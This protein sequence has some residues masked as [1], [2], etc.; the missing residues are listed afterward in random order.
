MASFFRSRRPFRLTKGGWIF[1]LYT[2]GVGAGAINTGNNLLYLIFGLF[3]GL[4][5]A[6]GVLSDLTLWKLDAVPVPPHEGRVG[7]P[8][9]FPVG[10]QNKKS[11]FPS[12]GVRIT[13]SGVLNDRPVEAAAF[14][15]AVEPAKALDT[16]PLFYPAE[17]GLLSLTGVTFSTRFPF[18][19]L[20]KRWSFPLSR[21]SETIIRP[22]LLKNDPAVALVA[23]STAA[24][25]QSVPR[26]GEGPTLFGIREYQAADNPRRIHWKASAKRPGEWLVREMEQEEAETVQLRWPDPFPK[27]SPA[28]FELFVSFA[29]TVAQALIARRHRVALVGGSSPVFWRVAASGLDRF[30]ALVRP[31]SPAGDRSFLREPGS[32]TDLWSAF[33]RAREEGE[34]Q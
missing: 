29:A 16:V 7:E 8:L 30:F 13:L 25:D 31:G 11:W 5:L 1:I 6:S 22:K 24:S 26:R 33:E 21:P 2:I 15:T 3:L 34:L 18:G 17:R 23:A 20:S 28:D 4:I 9:L 32:S 27:E 14:C 10:V 12:L 19:L